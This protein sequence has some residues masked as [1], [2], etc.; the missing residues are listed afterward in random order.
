M[1]LAALIFVFGAFPI[2]MAA[3]GG[4][5]VY[6]M[7][8]QQQA[9]ILARGYR[10]ERRCKFISDVPEGKVHLVAESIMQTDWRI[11]N[12]EKNHDTGLSTV[13]LAHYVAV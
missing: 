13:T 7:M 5:V 12:V 2:L 4:A 8:V 11:A 1:D 3:L 10:I 6:C 9:L